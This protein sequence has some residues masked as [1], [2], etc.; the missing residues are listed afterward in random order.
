MRADELRR[1]WTEFFAA[2]AHTDVPSAGL[3]P[4]HPSAPMFTNSGMMQFVPYFLGEEEVPFDPPRASSVQRCVRA[5]GKHNDL[6][7]IGRSMRH[8]SFFEMLGNFS[9][10]DYFKAEAI[11]WSWEFVTE[12]LGLDGD[13]IWVTVHTSDDEAGQIWADEVGLPR[14]RIQR[15][16]KDNFW[17]M[18]EV[19]PCGPSSE[20]FWDFGPSVGPEG[21]PANAAAEERYV[22]IWNLVFMQY[23]RG[24]DGQLTDLPATNVDTGAGLE[25]ILGVLDDSPSLYAAD[26]LSVLTDR[27]QEVTGKR[28]G[29]ERLADVALRLVADHTRT[30]AFLVADGVMPSNEDRG[31]VLRR[32]LRRAVY[33]SYL[34]GVE[35]PVLPPMIESCVDL[36][37]EAYPDLADSA[38][39][40][41]TIVSKEEERF[42]QTLKTG[43]T[44]LDAALDDLGP[45]E[46]GERPVLDG[47]VAFQLHDTYGFPLEVTQEIL[48]ERGVDLDVDGF[49]AAMADQRAR[50]KAAAKG[51]TVAVGDEIEA[52]RDVM[53]AAGPTE[54]VGRDTHTTTTTVVGVVPAERP[55]P[56]HGDTVSIF[57]RHTPFYAESGGQVGDTGEIRTDT[58][59]AEVLDTVYALPGLHQHIARITEGTIDLGAEAVATI[60]L[61]RRRAIMR[62]HTGTHIVHWALRQVLGD[63]VK[64]QG[65][66]VLPDRLR[67]DFSHFQALTDDEIARIEDLANHEI[68]GNADTHHYETTMDEARAKGAIAFFGDKYGDIVRVLE[69]GEHSIE[70]CGGTH[71]GRL[72]DIGPVKIIAEESVGSN[73]RRITAVAGTGPI[74]RLRER[75]QELAAVAETAGVPVSDVAGGVDRLREQ[76]KEAQD[77]VKSMRKQLSAGRAG[78]LADSAVDGKVVARVDGIERGDLRDMAVSLRDKPDIGVVVLGSAPEGGGAALVAATTD[79]SGVDA[80]E[81]LTDAKELIQGGGSNDPRLVMAGGKNADGV[82]PALDA[83]RATLGL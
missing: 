47:T 71:V 27:A 19:G 5:G 29:H 17:E 9:F 59:R 58:G 79:E 65:S 4:H 75:E 14:E 38:D 18:G 41:L 10:G 33:F 32:V 60:D 43:S 52:F 63:H 3:I 15:L 51:G 16:D 48:S 45:V 12:T 62:H 20:L 72:G 49:D 55:H 69:A 24:A 42:R 70:L 37:G 76:L 74:D 81:L 46:Q 21:G 26:T 67:F 36:M 35:R 39:S 54:F 8:L 44:M 83:V 66:I 28:F 61:E 50:A 73:L 82:D 77:E 78:D 13:R 7:A 53:S 2:R 30:V 22:E 57:L 6:D 34:L 64:Q 80:G 1:A 40:V 23:F 68:L 56:D 25:R 31:Y 11:P